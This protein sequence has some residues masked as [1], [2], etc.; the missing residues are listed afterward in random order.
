MIKKVLVVGGAG[1][2]GGGVVDELLQKKLPFTVYDNLTYEPHYFK[3]AEFVYGD[4]RDTRKLARMLPDYSHVIWL[5]ALVGDPA[6][7]IDPLLTKQI[8][9]DTVEWLSKNFDGRILFTSTCSVY[10]AVAEP[11]TEESAT[12][13][14]SE[15]AKTK[16]AAE[17]FL[18][19]KNS[20]IFRLGTAYGISDTYAR[21]RMDLAVN[22]MTMNA[23][24]RGFLEVYGGS[25]WRPFIHVN[26]IARFLVE[27]LDTSHT[28]IFNLA[29]ENLTIIDLAKKIQSITHCEVK[30]V[31]QKFVDDRS[32]NAVVTKA[33]TA[34]ILPETT[35]RDI[36]YGAT[37]IKNV[38]EQNRVNNLNNSFYSN[39]KHLVQILKDYANNTINK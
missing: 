28:G 34:G 26:D 29:T 4:V 12:G 22:Y 16:L 3:P 6:C 5:A 10:G 11:V 25:Q 14:L 15:Y 9:Q 7:A 36:L 8:N 20:L 18:K 2:I 19:D 39:A 27:N 38:V 35:E 31:E 17:S 37:Q 24:K 21:L 13:P 32:Y 23:L 30:A 33:R 1:Y